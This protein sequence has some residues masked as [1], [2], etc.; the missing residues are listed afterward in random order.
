MGVAA[1]DDGFFP[2]LYKTG[3]L[4][5]DNGLTEYSSP[6]DITDSYGELGPRSRH[7]GNK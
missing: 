1:D 3:D 2:A 4:R 5:D 7:L 6:Q